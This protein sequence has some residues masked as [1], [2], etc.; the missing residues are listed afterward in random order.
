MSNRNGERADGPSACIGIGRPVGVQFGLRAGEEREA[1]K[2][3][4]AGTEGVEIATTD[5]D[6][7][8]SAL[9]ITLKNVG[10]APVDMPVLKE[11]C[12]PDNGVRVES[13]FTPDQPGG[14]FG[15]GGGC[16]VS[17]QGTLFARVK[18]EW[19]RL[20]PGEWMTYTERVRWAGYRGR[21]PGTVEYWAEYQPPE[22]MAKD[23]SDLLL[24]GFVI[25]NETIETEHLSFH[26]R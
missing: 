5:E 26:M 6:G 3:C 25:P 21:G 15:E 2:P 13:N 24:A 16:G 10:G 14:F 11:A 20:R 4:E 18:H 19:V 7:Y 23:V 12:A 22:S 8:P 17:D 9:L 1:G